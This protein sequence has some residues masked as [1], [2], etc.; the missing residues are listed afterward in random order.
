MVGV[1]TSTPINN[2]LKDSYFWKTV[3]DVETR[4]GMGNRCYQKRKE[5]SKRERG[6][7]LVSFYFPS[8][9]GD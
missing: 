7:T 5:E 3:D 4:E 9:K 1:L 8:E 2:G 6:G